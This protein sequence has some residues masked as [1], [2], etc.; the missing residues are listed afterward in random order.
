MIWTFKT[1]KE[2]MEKVILNDCWNQV[3]KLRMRDF[4]VKILSGRRMLKEKP[5]LLKRMKLENSFYKN[6]LNGKFRI[7]RVSWLNPSDFS[8]KEWWEAL[9]NNFLSQMCNYSFIIREFDWSRWSRRKV[10]IFLNFNNI[11]FWF[12][13]V[14]SLDMLVFPPF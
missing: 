12:F 5:N 14:Y 6:L 2:K 3:I 7:Q 11:S 8:N 4:L 10:A 1:Y 9:L 13:H